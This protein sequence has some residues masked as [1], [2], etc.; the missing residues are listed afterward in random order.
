MSDTAIAELKSI[1]GDCIVDLPH[2][3]III[4]SMAAAVEGISNASLQNAVD[5]QPRDLSK[6]F[7]KDVQ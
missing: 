5:L 6:L 4:L 1:F 7:E 3:E 2:N